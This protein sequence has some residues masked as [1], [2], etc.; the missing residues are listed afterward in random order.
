MASWELKDV[1]L[2]VFTDNLVFDSV[3]Y[4]GTSKS[5]LLSEIFLRLYQ[6]QMIWYFILN[7]VNIS[8]TRVINTVNDGLSRGND[9]G[10]MM[11]LMNIIEHFIKVCLHLTKT[12]KVPKEAPMEHPRLPELP[13]LETLLMLRIEQSVASGELKDVELYV[14]TDNLVFDSLFYKG[15]SKIPLLSEIFLR[16]Y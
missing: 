12:R 6:V 13:I 5:P 16:L 1:E 10:G 14:F 11:R 3:F 9:L 2:F 15:T 8:V 4:K 7:V